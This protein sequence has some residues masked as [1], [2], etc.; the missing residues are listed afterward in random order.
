MRTKILAITLLLVTFFAVDAYSQVDTDELF[1]YG[2]VTTIDG[3]QYTG[4]IRWGTEEV[5][6]F[7]YFNATKPR[8]EYIQYLS[9]REMG[10][11]RETSQHWAER[12]VERVLSIDEGY[13]SF[14]HTFA[15]QFGD[16]KSIEVRSRN[17]VNVILKDGQV[18]RMDDGSNDVG[19]KIRVLDEEIVSVTQYV[20]RWAVKGIFY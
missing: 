13:N 7:D 5:F 18:I 14:S 16:L 9:R 15:C 11:L 19:A 12:W 17:R 1:I 20:E 8:N 4:M 2:K 3:D 6:W 10:E